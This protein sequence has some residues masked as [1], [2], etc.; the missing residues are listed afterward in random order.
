MEPAMQLNEGEAESPSKPDVIG[1]PVS[2][3]EIKSY[4]DGV[5]VIQVLIGSTE[6]LFK[7]QVGMN[8][9]GK[10]VQTA[11]GPRQLPPETKTFVFDLMRMPRPLGHVV[12]P[13]N[14]TL[15]DLFR[16]YMKIAES[17]YKKSSLLASI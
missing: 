7:G 2:V 3:Y 8:V 14:M 6:M 10:I 17:E 15:Q 9:P 13:T 1:T 5:N 16:R 4:T 12:G 11:S